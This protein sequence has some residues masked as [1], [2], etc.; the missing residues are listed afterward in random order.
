MKKTSILLLAIFTIFSAQAADI[1][2]NDQLIRAVE[3]NNVRLVNRLLRLGA[4][5]NYSN[6]APL[7]FA[8]LHRNKT[9]IEYL[10]VRGAKPNYKTEGSQFSSPL[11][12]AK[13]QNVPKEIITL[14][15]LYGH[16]Q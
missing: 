9:I 8:I 14:L 6:G 12:F 16:E 1:P 3:A 13:N 2:L 10:I 5:A 15:E 4:D 11:E 7:K